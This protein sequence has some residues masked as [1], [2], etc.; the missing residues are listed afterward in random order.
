MMQACCR[1]KQRQPD[2]LERYTSSN[3]PDFRQRA[4]D[5][6]GLYLNASVFC[7]DEKT[8]PLSARRAERMGSNNYRR[9]T[10]ALYAAF[11]SPSSAS[12]ELAPT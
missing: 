2:R 11:N 9:G 7:A 6:I 8:M 5:I 12:H 1:S 10:L 4:S 3:D